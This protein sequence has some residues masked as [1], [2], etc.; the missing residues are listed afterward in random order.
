LELVAFTV[1]NDMSSRDIEG[2]NPLYL[3]QAKLYNQCC[4]LGPWI[5]LSHAM[6]EPAAIGIHLTIRRAGSVAFE[7]HTS[8]GQMARSFDDLIGWVGRDNSF[9]NGVVLLTGTGIVPTSDFTLAANDVVEIG[10]DGIGTLVNPIV[11]G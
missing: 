7:G 11:Q 5:T 6:P 9:P 3:P 10:I 1:G 8:V 4:G 2:E